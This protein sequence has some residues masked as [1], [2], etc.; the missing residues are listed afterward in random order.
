MNASRGPQGIATNAR[1]L[2]SGLFDFQ[3]RTIITTQM[4]PIIYGMAVLLSALAAV[5]YTV[6]AFGESWWM[7][8]IWLILVGPA[9]FIALITSVRVV[10]EFVLTVFNISCY[11]DAMAGQVEGIAEQTEDI[12]GSLPRIKFWRSFSGLCHQRIV[13]F[14]KLLICNV[15]PAKAEIQ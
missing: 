3:F 4:M 12:S 1:T 5:Y 10:L 6:W 2:L 15:I 13:I 7:G 8:L 11:V 14:Y 9:L